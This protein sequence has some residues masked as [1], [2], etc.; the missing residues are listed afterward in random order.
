[1]QFLAEL[2]GTSVPSL[3]SPGIVLQY[4]KVIFKN[5]SLSGRMLNYKVDELSVI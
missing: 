3:N 2:L 1:M 4:F 5:S